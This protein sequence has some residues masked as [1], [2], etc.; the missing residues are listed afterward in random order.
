MLVNVCTA[1]SCSC[2][3]LFLKDNHPK[4]LELLFA[5][6]YPWVQAQND[7]VIC[8]ERLEKGFCR[9][10]NLLCDRTN[11]SGNFQRCA[12]EVNLSCRGV[13]KPVSFSFLIFNNNK[14][15]TT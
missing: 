2:A 9:F 15:K 14:K 12:S 1:V 8:S 4:Q 11:S 13:L 6:K 10:E 5:N 3:A 7:S